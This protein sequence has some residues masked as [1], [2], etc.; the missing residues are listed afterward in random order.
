MSWFVLVLSGVLEAV[1]ATAFGKSGQLQPG[2]A[3]ARVLDRPGTQ[4][5]GA[6]VRDAPASRRN[7]L[8]R[9]G[10]DRRSAPVAYGMT[11]G[12][13]SVSPLKLVFLAAIVGS[14]IGLKLTH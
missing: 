5:G 2:S 10:R 8:R 6:G 3:V 7:G 11:T 1:W 9:V 12:A 14:V 4:H 13:E